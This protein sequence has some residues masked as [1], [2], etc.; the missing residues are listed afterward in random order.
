[1]LPGDPYTTAYSWISLN[2]PEWKNYILR[3][4]VNDTYTNIGN[5]FVIVVRDGSAQRIGVVVNSL[6]DT[7]LALIGDGWS[8]NSPITDE[9][10]NFPVNTNTNVE[11]EVQN[12]NYILRVNGRE[13][14][15][16]TLSGFDSGGISIGL[17][18]DSDCPSFDDVKVT[19][20]P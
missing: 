9:K 14:Q 11:I 13:L 5:Q 7:Y 15:N 2:K 17:N 10:F 3:V 19:Y 6:A 8:N 16:I 18:C 4:N 20:L 1:M 12:D